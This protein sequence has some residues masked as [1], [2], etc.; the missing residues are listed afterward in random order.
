N[1]SMPGNIFN[2]NRYEVISTPSLGV[3]YHF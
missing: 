3:A 1:F 2:T